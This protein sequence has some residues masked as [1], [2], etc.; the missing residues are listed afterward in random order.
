M[1][2]TLLLFLVARITGTRVCFL[3]M[4]MLALKAWLA[5]RVPLRLARMPRPSGAGRS[6]HL[7]AAA[8]VLSAQAF[9]RG[10]MKKHTLAYVILSSDPV[11]LCCDSAEL[12][13]TA[14]RRS[15]LLAL[16]RAFQRASFQS[17][18]LLAGKIKRS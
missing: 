9:V 8:P 11:C 1:S 17:L 2:R 15:W 3:H 16:A 6:R 12:L 14:R 5:V 10:H 4:L 13:R 7:V 18:A